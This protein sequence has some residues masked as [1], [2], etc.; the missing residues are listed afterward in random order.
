MKKCLLM[1]ACLGLFFSQFV[2][3]AEKPAASTQTASQSS[4]TPE[5]TK[6]IQQ[7][8]H[9]YLVNQP[10]VL[11]EA[12]RA[13]QQQEAAR[14]EK[15]AMAAIQQNKQQL[16]NNPVS[17]VIGNPEGDVVMI[18]FYDYQCGHCKAMTPIVA[19]LI[20][21]NKDL[22]V[23]LKDWPIFG[24]N[25]RYAAKASVAV[26]KEDKDKY[27]AF[28][29]ALFKVDGPLSEDKVKAIAKQSG[30]DF[31]K[32]SKEINAP[33][34]EQQMKDNFELAQDLKLV[35]TPAFI[36]ANKALTQFRFVPGAISKQQLQQ[37]IDEVKSG[38]A[39]APTT[40]Q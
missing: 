3:A 9:D 31:S 6:A 23:I 17:P 18:E 37:L 14:A 12:S 22:K 29:E 39:A 1:I 33:Y 8:V 24:Q 25:S 19:N 40:Q 10:Q 27:F 36:V 38:S 2:L 11:I 21:E 26:A 35:G 32:I 30:V 34:T 15:I 5:Q 4:F 13:L 20:K 7:I 16:F 28:H